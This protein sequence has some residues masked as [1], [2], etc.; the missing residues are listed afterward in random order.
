MQ[1]R[2]IYQKIYKVFIFALI[3]TPGT[4]NVILECGN[5]KE[6]YPMKKILALLLAAAMLLCFGGCSE[7]EPTYEEIS[8]VTPARGTVDENGFYKNEAFGVSFAAE[9]DWYFLS[10]EEIAQSM[11]LAAEK[12]YSGEIPEGA[13]NIYDVYC[14]DMETNT[15]VS[16]NYEDLGTIG[17]FTEPNEY[18]E[19]VV[20][21]LLSA[22]E[23]SGIAES[24]LS[25][26]EIDGEK[27]PCLNITMEFS[28]MEIYQR[29]IVKKIGTWVGTVTLATLDEA[30]VDELCAK[31]SFK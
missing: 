28:G 15:T 4:K 21:Q 25:V 29:V 22:G 17:Q 11:G 13:D 30:E 20:T 31:I 10:D 7:E 14:V 3:F 26:T 2:L 9:K 12:I 19:M 5:R 1:I 8:E 27:V 24:E 16:V 6:V 18:L 23:D